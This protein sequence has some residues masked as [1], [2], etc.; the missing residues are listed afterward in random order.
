MATLVI[1][2]KDNEKDFITRLFK[3]MGIKH[4]TLSLDEIEEI[5]LA[6]AIKKGKSGKR[7]DADKFLKSL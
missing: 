2:I 6:N 5:G 7:I 3:K 4:Q 1:D